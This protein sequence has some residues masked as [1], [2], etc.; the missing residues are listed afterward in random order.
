[1]GVISFYLLTFFFWKK[2]WNPRF[3]HPKAC[4]RKFWLVILVLLPSHPPHHFSTTP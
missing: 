2:Q 1:V 3:T 4:E